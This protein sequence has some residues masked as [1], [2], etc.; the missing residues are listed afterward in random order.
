MKKDKESLIKISDILKSKAKRLKLIEKEQTLLIAS[1][2]DE[3]IAE[4]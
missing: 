2:M 3:A 4:M 1:K